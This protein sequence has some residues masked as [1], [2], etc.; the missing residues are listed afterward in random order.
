MLELLGLDATSE[1]VYREMLVHPKETLPELAARIGLG[2][3]GLKDVLGHL[4]TLALVRNSATPSG[5]RAVRASVGLDALIAKQ[6]AELAA[7]QQRLEASRAAAALLAAQCA[8]LD[9]EDG[10][11]AAEEVVGISEIRARLAEIGTEAREQVMTFAP[12]GAHTPEDLHAS[13]Q[14]NADLFERGVTVRTVYLDSIRNDPPTVDHVHWLCEQG[15]EVRTVPVLPLRMIIVDGRLA[16]L[17]ANPAA[18]ADGALIVR[19]RGTIAAL[20]AL[21][22]LVWDTGS[23][24]LD[25]GKRD[26]HGLSTQELGTLRLMR[27][28][29]TDEAIA[30]RLGVSPRTT[31]RTVAKLME[32]LD[33]K[34]RFEAG[35][36]ATE[37]G[38]FT[39]A[40]VS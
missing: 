26:E 13:R 6:Q 15:A 32:A 3:P 22:E 12:G 4:S 23:T 8:E 21:F 17:P 19:G 30:N 33:A 9:L 29:L 20:T 25:Q 14:P 34:S 2:E 24:L 35:C 27:A 40:S 18:A 7:Q 1:R 38:W 37:R 5:F 11:L 39:R 16:V 31:R 36:N 28:G 10:A